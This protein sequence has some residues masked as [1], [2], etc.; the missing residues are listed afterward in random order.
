MTCAA[1]AVELLAAHLRPGDTVLDAGCGSGYFFHSLN[2]RG[3]DVEYYGIDASPTLIEIGQRILPE[4]GLPAD[5][6][7]LLRIEDLAG[8]ADHVVCMNVLT[9][10]DN[11]HRP[12]ERLLAVA[13]RTLVLRESCINGGSYSYVRDEFL[14]PGADLFVHV[15]HYDPTAMTDLMQ[16]RGFSVERII[17]QRTGGKPEL[18]IGHPHHWTFFVATRIE[19]RSN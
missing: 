13:D 9:N 6:L 15:N 18:V 5:R 14:D 17:D 2:Q 16:D 11:F 3:L 19:P 10:I 4:H 8:R 1:Q 12:L 7:R